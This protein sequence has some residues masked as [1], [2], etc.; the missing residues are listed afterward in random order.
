[1]EGAGRAR[2]GGKLGASPPAQEREG[3]IAMPVA[4]GGSR[5]QQALSIT[6]LL[7][8]EVTRS[9]G[10][11]GG[12]AYP[13]HSPPRRHPR[14]LHG[15]RHAAAFTKERFIHANFRFVARSHPADGEADGEA[16]SAARSADTP[17]PWDAIEV[18]IVPAA[19]DVSCPICLDTPMAPRLTKCGHFFCWPCILRY[20]GESTSVLGGSGGSYRKCPVCFE[21]I[22]VKVIKS[23]HFT[24]VAD[25]TSQQ[26]DVAQLGIP[27]ALVV[28]Q[29]PGVNV[30]VVA[31]PSAPRHDGEEGTGCGGPLDAATTLA[32]F[33]P[34]KEE[35]T[36][37][38]DL[39]PFERITIVSKAFVVDN[40]IGDEVAA[41]DERL[42][43]LDRTDPDRAYSE[44]A[45]SM[46]LERKR[47]LELEGTAA[48]GTHSGAG[49][50]GHEARRGG[51]GGGTTT[52]TT[53]DVSPHATITAPLLMREAMERRSQQH[54]GPS[55]PLAREA[56]FSSPS[57]MPG[58]ASEGGSTGESP[59]I[60]FHQSIDG[61]AYFLCPLNI[62][63]LLAHFRRYHLMPRFLCAPVIEI[64]MAVMCE[65]LRKR[66]RYLSH[67]PLGCQFGLC[68]VDLCDVVDAATIRQFSTELSNRA[69]LRK[70]KAIRE[71][72][73]SVAARRREE[74]RNSLSDEHSLSVSL[75]QPLGYHRLHGG[76]SS[77][78][79]DPSLSSEGRSPPPP[80]ILSG[81]FA[82]SSRPIGGS[83]PVEGGPHQPSQASGYGRRRSTDA[84]AMTFADAGRIGSWGTSAPTAILRRGGGGGTP[85]AEAWRTAAVPISVATFSSGNGYGATESRRIVASHSLS[86][87]SFASIAAVAAS[88]KHQ[89][90]QED[91]AVAS[92]H[93]VNTIKDSNRSGLSAAIGGRSGGGG[94]AYA[95]NAFELSFDDLALSPPDRQ[96]ASGPGRDGE[97][98]VPA[99]TTTSTPASPTSPAS[100]AGEGKRRSRRIVLATTSPKRDLV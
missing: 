61:Q 83:Q 94:S 59:L 84:S 54:S 25:Y 80:G 5:R 28:A 44:L 38:L 62:K 78:S 18:V 96:Q 17:L 65:E 34:P 2:R 31:S 60:F 20:A 15:G 74:R 52:T 21:V 36:S 77:A 76:G 87:G 58:G 88:E 9:P 92:S 35:P 22:N 43:S 86:G 14:S 67:L 40:I 98:F 1:M 95:S 100:P 57:H 23:V 79:G 49:E 70:S 56:P 55:L 72:R 93:L 32:D 41:L 46:V 71:E 75:P 48:E 42:A 8:F 50:A 3:A 68:E 10:A 30:H 99:F 11:Y 63:M 73:H 81:L 53:I 26:A 64:Q 47:A 39:S 24:Q 82:S 16:A 66:H 6:H 90:G 69:S 85:G 33:V 12:S 97:P 91:A 27:M 89:R 37:F 4:S 19:H 13:S 29:P 7:S 45:L 51:G